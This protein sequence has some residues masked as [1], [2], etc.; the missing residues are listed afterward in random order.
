M[1]RNLRRNVGGFTILETIIVLTVMSALLASALVTLLA[2]LN[3]S[4][5]GLFWSVV[6]GLVFFVS[7]W[8]S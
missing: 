6:S 4:W 2:I 8:V 1:I 5:L 7:F 3:S